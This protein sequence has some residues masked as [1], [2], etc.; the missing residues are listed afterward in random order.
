MYFDGNPRRP[1]RIS[2]GASN[3]RQSCTE[4][5]YR[6]KREREMRELQRLKFEKAILIQSHVR[7]WLTQVKCIRIFRERYDALSQDTSTLNEKLDSIWCLFKC[8]QSKWDKM[9]V[10]KLS[11]WI[12]SHTSDV[13]QYSR[14]YKPYYLKWSLRLCCSCLLY[15]ETTNSATTLRYEVLYLMVV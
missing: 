6:N 11:Q 1:A 8:Y 2:L 12:L 15:H 4:L 9:R 5:L 10:V 3:K 13:T 14:Q 7:C